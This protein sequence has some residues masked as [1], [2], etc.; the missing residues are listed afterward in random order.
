MGILY[1]RSIGSLAANGKYI[2]PLDNDDLFIN[3]D[4]IETIYTEAIEAYFDIIYFKGI[5]VNDFSDFL[6]MKNLFDF[7]SF[8]S[9]KILYQ[10]ELWKYAI[11]RFVLWTQCIKTELYKKSINALGEE[12]YSRYLTVYEDAI[13]NY[14]NNQF[15]E[16]AKLF[17]KYGI[18]H[19]DKFG[20]T[21]RSVNKLKKGL[22]ELYFIETIIDFSGNK[23]SDREVAVNKLNNLLD[24]KYIKIILNSEKRKQFFNSLI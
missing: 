19:M 11:N 6:K 21:S 5:L 23:I 1:T 24:K 3:M 17:L 18:L 2:F 22:Y 4:I 13:I 20:S 7:R 14:I 8:K 16:N 9:N 15:A 12:R 10:P